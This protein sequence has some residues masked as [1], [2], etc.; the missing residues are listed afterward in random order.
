MSWMGMP[1]AIHDKSQL[2]D[3]K[4]V[5][6]PEKAVLV[7]GFFEAPHEKTYDNDATYPEDQERCRRLGSD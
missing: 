6:A 7:D 1:G 3:T 4:L 5:A 2:V